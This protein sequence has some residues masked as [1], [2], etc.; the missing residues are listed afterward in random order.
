MTA[1]K[2]GFSSPS[3]IYPFNDPTAQDKLLSISKLN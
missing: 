2:K 1:I 3:G